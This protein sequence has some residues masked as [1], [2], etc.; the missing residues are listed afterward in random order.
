MHGLVWP[1]RPFLKSIFIGMTTVSFLLGGACTE[2]PKND[3]NAK[4]FPVIPPIGNVEDVAGKKLFE[5][6][7]VSP[8]VFSNPGEV[9]G[10]GSVEDEAL[11]QANLRKPIDYGIGAG[12]ITMDTTFAESKKLLTPPFRGPFANGMALYNEQILVIWKDEGERKPQLIIPMGKYLGKMAAGKFGKLDFQTKFTSYKGDKP[13][14]GAARLARE[15]FIELEQIEDTSYDCLATNRCTLIYGAENQA[16]MVMVFPG[17]V[18]L[19]A[20]EEFQLAE[21]RI[22]RDVDPG[23]LANNLDI[24]SGDVLVP[25]EAPFQLGQAHKE[26]FDRVNSGPVETNPEVYVRTNFIGYSWNGF[27][28]SFHRTNYDLAVTQAEDTDRVKNVEINSEFPALLTVGGVP[29]LM[30]IIDGDLNISLMTGLEPEPPFQSMLT[31]SRPIPQGN[32]LEFMTEFGD[33][34]KTELAK[35]YDVITV[36][37][38][39]WQNPVKIHKE[40]TTVI[41]AYKS[42]DLKGVRI[43]FQLNEEQGKLSFF[44]VSLLDNSINAFNKLILPNTLSDLS[45]T[46]GFF[47]ELSGIRLNDG[48]ALSEIDALGR[49]EATAEFVRPSVD[50]GI[51]E[52]TT[53]IEQSVFD[54]PVDNRPKPRVQSFLAVASTGTILGLQTI[55]SGEG[56]AFARVVSISSDNI[57]GSIKD[58]CSFGPNFSIKIGMTDDDV[59]KRIL[60]AVEEQ[61]AINPKYKCDHLKVRD[62]G[63]LGLVKEIYFPNERLVLNFSNRSLASISIYLP[64]NEV[65][66]TMPGVIQ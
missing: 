62:D 64:L 24:L 46:E 11:K 56:K 39:G 13:E 19:L 16:N 25:H 21:I 45:R 48:I 43:T 66:Q 6:L 38:Q 28:Y 47:T 60:I 41:Q 22:I 33:F 2:A 63:S 35:K 4:A 36:R 50:A 23:I 57:Y 34:L 17:A 10:V 42:S 5:Q 27:W 32:S 15:L 65:D 55:A 61:K 18:L 3:G 54:V 40:L 26:I 53:Y 58:V 29:V 9:T 49:L 20:K 7:K 8:D 31:M 30:D 44:N 52:R 59:L 37:T 12:G 14:Q 1:Q 51:I